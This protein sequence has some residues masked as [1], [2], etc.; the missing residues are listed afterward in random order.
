M[1]NL[2]RAMQ[3]SDTPAAWGRNCL[4][5]MRMPGFSKQS[6]VMIAATSGK[7]NPQ[8]RATDL[9]DQ[10][11]RFGGQNRGSLR[12]PRFLAAPP[13]P[14]SN[15][16]EASVTFLIEA[17]RLERIVDAEHPSNCLTFALSVLP[18]HA[19]NGAERENSGLRLTEAGDPPW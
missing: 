7:H 11:P 19:L 15:H 5:L 13:T 17:T 14:W 9:R 12:S 8:S 18:A 4:K 6:N 2:A 10:Y 1:A 3:G 16:Q